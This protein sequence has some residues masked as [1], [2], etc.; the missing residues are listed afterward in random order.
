VDLARVLSADEV[1]ELNRLG[2]AVHTH[3]GAEMAIVVV[4]TIGGGDHRD[5]ATRLFNHWQ[6]GDRARDNGLLI[7]VAVGD[8]AAEIILGNGIDSDAEVAKSDRVMQGEMVPRFR[9]G[10]QAGAIL[11]GARACAR[12]FFG[13]TAALDPATTSVEAPIEANRL[14]PAQT[15]AGPSRDRAAPSTASSRRAS[16]NPRNR[17]VCRDGVAVLV[18][19]RFRALMTEVRV[20]AVVAA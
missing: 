17:R 16:R 8:R 19:D 12:E 15:S 3:D 10:D 13:A 18:G 2:D 5:F 20:A 9:S 14:Q 7:F 11:A 1:A 4:P 6:I